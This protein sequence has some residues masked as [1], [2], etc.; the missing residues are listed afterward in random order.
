MEQLEDQREGNETIILRVNEWVAKD[1]F[2]DSNTSKNDKYQV[3]A[4]ESKGL[5][6]LVKE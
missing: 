3:E 4:D 1:S 2:G 6:E 5:W